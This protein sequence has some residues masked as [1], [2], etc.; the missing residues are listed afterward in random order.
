M[1]DLLLYP[2]YKAKRR[3]KPKSGSTEDIIKLAAEKREKYKYN[4]YRYFLDVWPIL[5]PGTTLQS[6]WHLELICEYL[7][8]VH[9]RIC[10]KLLINIAPRHLKSTLC[11]V[12]FPTWEWLDT[13]WFTHLCIS[14]SSGL[15]ND[16]SDDRRK[17][18]QSD[19]YR[20]LMPRLH[21]SSSKN[22]ISEFENNYRGSMY[23]RGLDT[24]V[25]GS[26]GLGQIYDDPNNP[27]KADSEKIVKRELDGYRDYSVSRRNDPVN[28]YLIV[29]QQRVSM[30]DVSD[31]IL[32]NDE[33]FTVLN[34]PT[35]AEKDQD[36][37]FPISGRVVRRKKGDFLHPQRFGEKEVLEAKK[38]MGI[39]YNAQHQQNPV[40]A[41]GNILKEKYWGYYLEAPQCEFTLWAWDTAFKAGDHNDYSAGVL[42][43]AYGNHYYLLDVFRDRMETPDVKKK[44]IQLYEENPSNAVLIE[45]KASGISLYQELKRDTLLPLIAVKADSDKIARVKMVSPTVEAGKV[46]LPFNA[47]WKDEFIRETSCFPDVAFDDQ[48]DAFAHGMRYLIKSYSL[49]FTMSNNLGKRRKSYELNY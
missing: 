40:P 12:V 49:S 39:R 28:Y 42:L 31:Y 8:Q 16:L 15:A 17:I 26:G 29:I 10:K 23:A 18:I 45:D 33:E 32:K 5:E 35:E 30:Q 46:L 4:L 43:G 2:K 9:Y 21:L 11:S 13:P 36:I 48:T 41:E 27:R 19:F 20:K 1:K 37:V 44:I 22:R 25:T 47:R 14:Y 24:G 3:Q 6:N 38:S 34:L 7:M